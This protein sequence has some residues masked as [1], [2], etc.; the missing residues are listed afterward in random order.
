[1]KLR[2]SG[3]SSSLVTFGLVLIACSGQ[4][5]ESKQCDGRCDA[6]IDS[7]TSVAIDADPNRPDAPP[8]A[9]CDQLGGFPSKWIS[10][11]PDCGSEPAI[12][13]HQ[14]NADTFI[15]RQSLCTSDEAPFF[16]LLFGDD[17]ALL[18]DTGDGGIDLVG[19]VNT[20][21]EEREAQVGHDIEL[22]V[23][24]SHA[25]GDHTQSN[26]AFA[27]DGATV[28]G[29]NKAQIMAF[30]GMNWPRDPVAYDLGGRIVDVM[31][32]PGH[33]SNHVAIYD[34]AYGLL[35]TGDTV[36]P[37]RLF[38]QSGQFSEYKASIAFLVEFTATREVC[39]VL[40]THIEM[41]IGGEDYAFGV[42]HHPEER[43]LQLTR[44]TLLELDAAVQAMGDTPVRQ[45]HDDFIVYPLFPLSP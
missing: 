28:V 34:R 11:G 44:A 1:M 10:G 9:F 21:V 18:Q 25:H 7:G 12:Q 24:N 29:F 35:L 31:G 40:G 17:K 5:S 36:Y 43:E 27:A 19:T 14:L 37:G 42:N 30:F 23:T 16:Y 8:A 26:G 13:V 22:V 4:D 41:S 6:L 45:A 38:I 3:H 32:T 2:A 33:E 39:S 20:I 15:L